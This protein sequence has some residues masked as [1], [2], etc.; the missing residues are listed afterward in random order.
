MYVDPITSHVYGDGIF[1]TLFVVANYTSNLLHMVWIVE[2]ISSVEYA[3]FFFFS[4]T[5][6]VHKK[7][8]LTSCLSY[9]SKLDCLNV[10]N[11]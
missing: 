4:H 11:L 2:F 3:R 1:K 9:V 7:D 5:C 8:S 10:V 6:M